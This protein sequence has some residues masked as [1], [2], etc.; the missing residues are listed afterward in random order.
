MKRNRRVWIL[1]LLLGV[2]SP[3]RRELLMAHEDH[4]GHGAALSGSMDG[5]KVSHPVPDE[6]AWRI[7]F[8]SLTGTSKSPEG[9]ERQ[10]SLLNALDLDEEDAGKLRAIL[11]D[12]DSTTAPFYEHIRALRVYTPELETMRS[13]ISAATTRARYALASRLSSRGVNKVRQY[14]DETVRPNIVAI[15]YPSAPADK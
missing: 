3:V 5:G 1:V 12:F 2:A 4:S 15:P 13:S 7:F 10:T 6:V 14:L 8:R 11:A 9:V